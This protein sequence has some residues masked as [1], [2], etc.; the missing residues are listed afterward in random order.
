MELC[1]DEAARRTRSFSSL[2]GP[3]L[4]FS[5]SMVASSNFWETILAVVLFLTFLLIEDDER[6]SSRS[7]E[8]E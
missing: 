6:G 5:I 3:P 7:C 4:I 8:Q 1:K 2:V